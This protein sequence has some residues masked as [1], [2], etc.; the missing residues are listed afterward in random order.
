VAGSAEQKFPQLVEIEGL[1]KRPNDWIYTDG[2]EPPLFAVI[3]VDTT[4]VPDY[5]IIGYARGPFT[6]DGLVRYFNNKPD[7]FSDPRDPEA[8]FWVSGLDTSFYLEGN[9]PGG[10][11][12]AALN[13]AK[14]ILGTQAETN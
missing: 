8:P 14:L 10:A 12:N 7:R 5:D 4:A 1:D 2:N 6:K 11:K 3:N 13:C 9:Y